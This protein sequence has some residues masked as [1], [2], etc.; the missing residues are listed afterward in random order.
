MTTKFEVVAELRNHKGTLSIPLSAKDLKG[1][2]PLN[3]LPS[4]VVVSGRQ[5]NGPCSVNVRT[6]HGT[7]GIPAP[8]GQSA[9]KIHGSDAECHGF[10]IPDAFGTSEHITVPVTD[11]ATGSEHELRQVMA[12]PTGHLHLA[13]GAAIVEPLT[14]HKRII[15]NGA[16]HLAIRKGTALHAQVVLGA[17]K[18]APPLPESVKHPGHILL[19]KELATTA[20]AD[21]TRMATMANTPNGTGLVVDVTP[22][23]TDKPLNGWVTVQFN[24]SMLGDE[25]PLSIPTSSH[26]D[27]SVDDTATELATEIDPEEEI[28][29]DAE[30]SADEADYD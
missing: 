2:P 3:W 24:G 15:K 13:T 20:H 5:L 6:E 8:A 30:Q 29:P 25:H 16:E 9:V 21:L 11:S 26:M 28:D 23:N 27:D 4:S 14:A 19:T 7:D 12:S 22:H 1:L 10:L 17:G 18:D